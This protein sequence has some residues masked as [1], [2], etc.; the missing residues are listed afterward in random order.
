[1]TLDKS[2]KLMKIISHKNMLFPQ[3][4]LNTRNKKVLLNINPIT[5]KKLHIPF[6][7]I[8]NNKN[9]EE[10]S[11]LSYRDTN[12]SS[13]NSKLKLSIEGKSEI[14][15]FQ[16]KLKEKEKVSMLI[17]LLNNIS[18]KNKKINYEYA[19]KK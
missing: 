7:S 11:S 16:I 8:L 13:N 18:L 17:S 3:K 9:H 12:A 4:L 2:K 6:N 5:I 19:F 1:M 10:K 15:E 14:K